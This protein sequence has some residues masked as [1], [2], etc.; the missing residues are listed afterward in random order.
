ME[1]LHS[2]G[3]FIDERTE[4]IRIIPEDVEEGSLRLE[5][6]LRELL[7]GLAMV[8]SNL[9]RTGDFLRKLDD[10]ENRTLNVEIAS[11]IA[12]II[13]KTSYEK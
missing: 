3:L 2:I 9:T 12:S 7:V 6:N 4:R 13:N 5:E 11:K 1:D 8:Q 10:Q